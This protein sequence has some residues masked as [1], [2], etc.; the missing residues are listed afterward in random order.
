MQ[1]AC[2][3]YSVVVTHCRLKMETIVVKMIEV[4][5]Y[6]R[7]S[8]SADNTIREVLS[9]FVNGCERVS[10]CITLILAAR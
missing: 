7:S 3:E 9:Q 10:R 1:D 2:L 6:E 8:L 4:E 5:R